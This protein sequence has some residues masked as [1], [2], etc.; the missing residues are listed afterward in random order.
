M[1]KKQSMAIL[2]ALC[3]YLGLCD[4]HIALFHGTSAEPQIVFPYSAELLPWQDQQALKKGIPC[5]T[6]EELARLLED[7][8]S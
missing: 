1:K 5:P 2:L 8:L 6:R 3:C 7:Y 4:G